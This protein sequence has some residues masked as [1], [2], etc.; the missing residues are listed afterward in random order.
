MPSIIFNTHRNN[1]EI[2]AK[3]KYLPTIKEFFAIVITFTLT[4]FAWIFFRAESLSHAMHYISQIFTLSLFSFPTIRPKFLFIL[5]FIFILI[6]WFGRE[7]KYAIARL[8]IKWNPFYRYT[9][10]YMMII[11]IFWFAGKEQQFIYFQF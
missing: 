8:G 2:V 4:V 1:L 7:E 6:E 3:G 10:Y 11:A 5:L 9:M